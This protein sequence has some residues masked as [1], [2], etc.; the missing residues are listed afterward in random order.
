MIQ[1]KDDTRLAILRAAKTEFSEKGFSGARMSCIAEKAKANQALIHYYF[2]SKENLYKEVLASL[3]GPEK[4]A[5]DPEFRH[6]W[7]IS[8][9]QKLFLVLHII[10]KIH[11]LAHDRE[12]HRIFLWEIA[13]GRHFIRP[14][15]DKYM[16]PRIESMLNIIEKGISEG[17]FQTPSPMLSVMNLFM[18]LDGI[19]AQTSFFEG[20]KFEPIMT[21]EEKEKTFYDYTITTFFKSIAPDGK[22]A[23]IPAVPDDLLAFVDDLLVKMLESS[24]SEFSCKLMSQIIALLKA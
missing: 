14:F 15:I 16:V 13:E 17:V 3:F 24:D 8:T 22:A 20:T 10:A 9:Q 21:K 19:E 18:L 2:G 12:G 11:I 6:T 7:Q 23:E 4:C 5:G 1:E